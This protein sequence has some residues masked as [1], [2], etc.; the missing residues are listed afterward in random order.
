VGNIDLAPTFAAVGGV[1]APGVDGRSFLGLLGNPSAAWRPDLL[2]ENRKSVTAPEVPSY[3]VVRTARHS[4]VQYGTGE[5]EL[6][7]IAADPGQLVNRARNPDLRK[8]LVTFRQRTRA[9]CSPPPPRMTL[10]ST[11]LI[12]GTE[13]ANRLHGT[14]AF[15]Y[16]CAYG[17][18]DRVQAR[19]GDD[20]LYG[21]LGNDVL[22]GEGGHDRIYPGLGLDRVYG[23]IGRDV[24]YAADGR[25]DVVACGEGVDTVYVNPGDVVSGCERI[26]RSYSRPSSSA[27]ARAYTSRAWRTSATYSRVSGNSIS[28]PSASH[29][30]TFV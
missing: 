18:A 20:V 5:E 15:D 29:S 4:Y 16:V 1:A 6:Y 27:Y 3:C 26:R 21:G 24:V 9:L 8:L 13:R 7:V 14:P 22:Y 30:S 12:A 10:R 23:G 28:P 25:R 2:V 19:S 17:G 11:C